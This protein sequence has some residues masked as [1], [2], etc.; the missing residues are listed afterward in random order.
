MAIARI[1]AKLGLDV[2]E[3]QVGLKRAGQ[4]A[5]TFA[6]S[7]LM[8]VKSAIAGAFTVGSIVYFA[9]KV[10]KAADDTLTLAK[11]TGATTDTLQSLTAAAKATGAT[12]EQMTQAI[13]KLRDAQGE[14]SRGNEKMAKSFELLGISAKEVKGMSIDALFE[15]VSMALNDGKGGVGEYSAAID[16]LGKS[17]LPGLN[18]VFKQVADDGLASFNKE[19]KEATGYLSR[20]EIENLSIARTQASIGAQKAGNAG[21][22]FLGNFIGGFRVIAGMLS[23]S[24]DRALGLSQ[25]KGSVFSSVASDVVDLSDPSQRVTTSDERARNREA[26]RERIRARNSAET[27]RPGVAKGKGPIEAMFEASFKEDEARR[28]AGRKGQEAIQEA[29][30]A[31]EAQAEKDQMARARILRG[32]GIS[33]G[34]PQGDSLARIGGFVG[35][36]TD[37]MRGAAE[38]QIRILEDLRSLGREIAARNSKDVSD[39]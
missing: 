15:R 1:L 22:S 38:R 29:Q 20:E 23:E 28:A 9:N 12:Q 13:H 2:S 31:A 8:Q 18:D 27:Y 30:Y 37:P 3:W 17:A 19:M 5:D 10:S 33:G 32:E 16:V 6:K 26:E 21:A 34:N 14:V 25:K 36:R 35:G 24:T 7:N 11:A 39:N 4:Q